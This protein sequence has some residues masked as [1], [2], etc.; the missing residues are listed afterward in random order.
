MLGNPGFL[1]AILFLGK[2]IIDVIIV[3]SSTIIFMFKRGQRKS[4]DL[5]VLAHHIRE[6]AQAA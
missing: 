1:T 3:A 4:T 5:L 2:I 6:G